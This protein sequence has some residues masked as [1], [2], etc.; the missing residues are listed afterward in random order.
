MMA[1]LLVI[2]LRM[3]HVPSVV[4]NLPFAVVS[5]TIATPSW[6][7]PQY[8]ASSIKFQYNLDPSVRTC[9]VQFWN[10]T[11]VICTAPEGVPRSANAVSASVFGATTDSTTVPFT[12]NDANISGGQSFRIF[13]NINKLISIFFSVT[14]VSIEWG[15]CVI[16]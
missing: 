1:L 15:A 5:G 6:Y 3:V 12:Y 4:V 13:R 9:A 16:C 8:G 14:C 10:D 7:N 2:K 11:L